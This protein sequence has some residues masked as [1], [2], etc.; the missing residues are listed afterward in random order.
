MKSKQAWAGDGERTFVLNGIAHPTLEVTVVETLAH[1]PR[2][3]Q[4]DLGI[5]LIDL[6]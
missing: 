5:A 1:L 4:P 2:K 3:A 6:S